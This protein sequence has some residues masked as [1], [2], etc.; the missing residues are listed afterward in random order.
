MDAVIDLLDTRAAAT[1]SDDP[2]PAT[3]T[4]PLPIED[5]ARSV[6]AT[7]SQVPEE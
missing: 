6:D 1:A 2:H 5:G 3:P 4:K 7:S